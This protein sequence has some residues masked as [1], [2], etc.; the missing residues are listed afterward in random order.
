[1]FFQCF[2]GG[3]WAKYSIFGDL[4]WKAFFLRFRPIF[5]LSSLT[6]IF[7]LGKM[8]KSE[9]FWRLGLWFKKVSRRSGQSPVLSPLKKNG[10]FARRKNLRLS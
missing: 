5:V 10:D 6:L 2:G 7:P 1:M 8:T 4:G 9:R 3:N